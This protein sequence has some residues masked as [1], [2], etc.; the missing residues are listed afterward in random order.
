VGLVGT[1]ECD[2]SDVGES[3]YD[4]GAFGCGSALPKPI[5]VVARRRSESGKASFM[6]A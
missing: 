2:T 4:K 1:S 6:A 3:E 5:A